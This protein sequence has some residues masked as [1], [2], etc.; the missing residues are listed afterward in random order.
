MNDD[1]QVI[2]DSYKE[3]GD[4]IGRIASCHIC[5]Y[6][7]MCNDNEVKN[8]TENETQRVTDVGDDDES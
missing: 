3:K 6:H 5:P 1:K 7:K 8:D 2:K 4:L